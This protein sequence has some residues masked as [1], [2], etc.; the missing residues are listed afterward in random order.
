MESVIVDTKP[1]PIGSGV[2]L[3]P[4]QVNVEIN[5][6]GLSFISPELVKFKYKLAGLDEDWVDAGTRRTA[7]YA[8]LP[9]GTYSFR[10]AAANRDGIWNEVGATIQI[11]VVPPFWRTRWFMAGALFALALLAYGFYQRRISQLK[12]AHHAQAR[13]SQQLIDSQEAERKRI[14][15]EL[16][17]SLGQGLLIIKNRAALTRK[18]LDDPARSLEQIDQ[19]EDTAAQSIKEVRQIAYDLR[20][21]QLDDI[22]LTQALKDLVKRVSESCPIKFNAKID[23]IDDLYSVDAA[24][25]VYRILQE[26]V[27]NIVKHSEASEAGVTITRDEGDVEM[28]I[29]DNGRGFTVNPEEAGGARQ[30]FGLTRLSERADAERK[31]RR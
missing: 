24:I 23:P 3:E 7:Y 6:T 20:P 16:H 17:D 29:K 8:H 12:R 10:V 18:L 15:A 4:G 19:R 25:N 1:V 11:V 14:A 31:T 30:G 27:N 21:Y 9:P 28:V 2:R 5:Y 13:F 22:G 26:S